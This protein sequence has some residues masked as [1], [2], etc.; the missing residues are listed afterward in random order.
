MSSYA[1]QVRSSLVVERVEGIPSRDKTDNWERDYSAYFRGSANI[2]QVKFEMEKATRMLLRRDASQTE[3]LTYSGSDIPPFLGRDI[4]LRVEAAL[5]DGNWYSLLVSAW[6]PRT[7]YTEAEFRRNADKA[8]EFW[9]RNL[10]TA[11]SPGGADPGSRDLYDQRV[12]GALE[13]EARLAGEEEDQ[14]PVTALKQEILAELRKGRSFRTAHHEGGTTIYFDGK[15]FVHS[16]YG[17][18]ESLDVLA[19]DHDALDRI[20]ALYDW[21]SRKGS[22]P[23]PPPE[24]EVWRFIQRQL[25]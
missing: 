18:E 25:T 2:L 8:F 20:R 15:T 7:W 21:D 22:F 12:R 1:G 5:P 11:P 13:E 24:L 6:V 3:R 10:R 19:T 9:T 4:R 23:H 14:A 17:E 16:T